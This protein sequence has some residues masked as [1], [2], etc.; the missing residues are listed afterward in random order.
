MDAC[1]SGELAKQRVLLAVIYLAARAR[2]WG[3][4]GG[5]VIGADQCVVRHDLRIHQVQA[6]LNEPTT[7]SE[8]RAARK[9]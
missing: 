8:A 1:A 9:I 7:S 2:I 6:Q 5:H 3:T 4:T